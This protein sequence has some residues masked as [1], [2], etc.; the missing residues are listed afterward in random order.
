MVAT[1]VRCPPLGVYHVHVLRRLTQLLQPT[2][3]LGRRAV[4]RVARV[5]GSTPTGGRLAFQPGAS[6]WIRALATRL[7]ERNLAPLLVL[8]LAVFAV[9]RVVAAAHPATTFD[10]TNT[11]LELNF[12]GAR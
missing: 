6:T 11:Y 7:R 3:A 1:D 12:L 8:V 2:Q 4:A 5:D 10:D 9:L